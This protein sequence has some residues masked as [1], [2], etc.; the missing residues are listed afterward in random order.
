MFPFTETP[1]SNPETGTE[2][3][4]ERSSPAQNLSVQDVSSKS[5]PS[6]T[7]LGYLEEPGGAAVP[8]ERTQSVCGQEGGKARDK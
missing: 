5:K 1:R 7:L 8:K 4:R 2:I 6:L 3:Q